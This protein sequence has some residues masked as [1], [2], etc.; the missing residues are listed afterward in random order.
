MF[1]LRLFPRPGGAGI[2]VVLPSGEITIML[3]SGCL[4]IR[5]PFGITLTCGLRSGCNPLRSSGGGRIGSNGG[6]GTLTMTSGALTLANE[7]NI[8]RGVG[9]TSVASDGQVSAVEP[10]V[11]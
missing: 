11:R 3:P 8:G 6:K 10:A 5:P 9:A 2:V 7:L 1:P 4:M